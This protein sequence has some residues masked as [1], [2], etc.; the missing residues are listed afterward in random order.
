MAACVLRAFWNGDRRLILDALD[1]SSPVVEANEVSA[2]LTDLRSAALAVLVLG[3]SSA[4]AVVAVGVFAGVF[5]GVLED[6]IDLAA[7]GIPRSLAAAQGVASLPCGSGARG[8]VREVR[9]F[10]GEGGGPMSNDGEGGTG[11]GA[12]RACKGLVYTCMGVAAVGVAAVGVMDRMED[13]RGV[14]LALVAVVEVEVEVRGPLEV[15]DASGV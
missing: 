1:G 3:V 14:G 9:R 7:E 6:R 4:A 2:K 10:A 5:A 13:V 15:C 11:I 8:P 12:R